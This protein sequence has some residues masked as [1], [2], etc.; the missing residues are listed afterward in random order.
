[1]NRIDSI[2]HKLS[3]IQDDEEY[4]REEFELVRNFCIEQDFNLTDPEIKSIKAIGMD[5][6]YDEWRRDA[7]KEHFEDKFAII[8]TISAE[9]KWKKGDK[10]FFVLR[11]DGIAVYAFEY[12][13]FI[14]AMMDAEF[15]GLKRDENDYK[16][17]LFIENV[18]EITQKYIC[19]VMNHVITMPEDHFEA[20]N[21]IAQIAKEFE[22]KFPKWKID[23]GELDYIEE[24]EKYSEK[25]FMEKFGENE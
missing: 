3:K 15:F 21:T 9:D 22:T 20:N 1:M 23:S 14:D 16:E 10:Q 7:L 18:I 17:N 13:C 5:E 11:A 12:S 25:R 19:M 8:S 2:L 6:Y 24:I 4:I